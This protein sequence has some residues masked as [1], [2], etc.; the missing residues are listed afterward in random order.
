[1]PYLYLS[2]SV[3]FA[4]QMQEYQCNIPI[5]SGGGGATDPSYIENAGDAAEYV[6]I[7]SSWFRCC[8]DGLTEKGQEMMVA[9]EEEFS[10]KYGVD[11]VMTEPFANGWMGAAVLVDALERCG[12]TETQ[13]LCDAIDSTSL[14]RGD[15]ALLFSLYDAITFEDVDGMYNQNPY[16]GMMAVQ[17]LNGELK[18][19]YPLADGVENPIVWPIP[20]YNER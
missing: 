3:L 5:L 8:Y 17:V 10:E 4:Q 7:N 1:M 14:K 18:A 11:Y 13:A 19:I 2:D 9:Y 15:D 16:A 12:T 6:L 20:A